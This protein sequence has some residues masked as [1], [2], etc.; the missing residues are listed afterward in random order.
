MRPNLLARDTSPPRS[1]IVIVESLLFTKKEREAPQFVMCS[2]I[3]CSTLPE[4]I[5]QVENG[6]LDDHFP[7]QVVVHLDESD[8]ECIYYILEIH[9]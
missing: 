8:L 6:L 1:C 3:S 2:M 7:L 9:T 4:T 5:M